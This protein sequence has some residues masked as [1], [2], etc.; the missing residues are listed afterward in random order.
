MSRAWWQRIKADPV[1]LAE[2]QAKKR[3]QYARRSNAEKE[4][5]R[6]A[7]R[8]RTL[9]RS[10]EEIERE[11]LYQKEYRQRIAKDPVRRAKNAATSREQYRARTPEQIEAD[12]ERGRAKA[13]RRR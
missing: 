4:R 2:H 10:P 9:S 1:L 12:R 3:E 13:K 7:E 11:K 8:L 6:A 5:D